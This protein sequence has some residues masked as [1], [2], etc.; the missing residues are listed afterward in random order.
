VFN[1]HT[2]PAYTPSSL[3]NTNGDQTLRV[4]IVGITGRMGQQFY[5]HCQGHPT[6]YTCVG[7]FGRAV[8]G[9]SLNVPLFEDLCQL[10]QSSQIILDFSL[11]H[12]TPTLLSAWRSCPKPLLVGTTGHSHDLADQLRASPALPGPIL[13]APNTAI[14]AVAQRL[15]AVNAAQILGPAFD[16]DLT[17]WHHRGK[18]DAP[19][20]TALALAKSVAQARA[21]PMGE[22]P[23]IQGPTSPRKENTIVVV[24]MR[25]GACPGQHSLTLTSKHEQL[26]L[27]YTAFDKQ[28]YV[29]GAFAAAQWL[30]GKP[31]GLYQMEDFLASMPQV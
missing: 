8:D 27:T 20:G 14:G 30:M 24:G 5:Q 26:T 1:H 16:I 6:R 18:Q 31:A 13:L 15:L 17:E 22:K 29:L 2:T 9:L 19:S 7:G 23:D 28:A 4:G 12:L 11:P 3:P 10:F 21:N 25:A